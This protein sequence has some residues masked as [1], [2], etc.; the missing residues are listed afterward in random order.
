MIAEFG[1]AVKPSLNIMDG[2]KA[3]VS[4]GPSRGDLVEPKLIVASKD[5]IATDVTGIGILKHY[6]TEDRLQNTS[7]WQQPMIAHGISI[8][9]G[10]SDLS[11]IV[12]KG[13]KVPELEQ[14]RKQ[15]I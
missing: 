14:I 11:R 10:V 2:T 1:L 6:G 3:F 5:R 13:D 8:G 7:V 12:L 9:L 4:H 15:M